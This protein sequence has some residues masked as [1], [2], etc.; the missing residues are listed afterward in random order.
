MC[1]ADV[2]GQDAVEFLIGEHRNLKSNE[3]GND[4][5]RA[6]VLCALIRTR[7]SEG[8]HYALDHTEEILDPLRSKTGFDIYGTG[9]EPFVIHTIHE[10]IKA[11]NPSELNPVAF[12]ELGTV[13]KPPNSELNGVD[14]RLLK[15]WHLP[16]AP[17]IDKADTI[18]DLS[19]MMPILRE[20]WCKLPH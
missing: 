10:L 13:R 5:R 16:S 14:E 19:G 6:M 20:R 18:R 8:V 17:T 11:N 9:T 1:Y 7:S 2:A 4:F 3:D 15:N 12:Y